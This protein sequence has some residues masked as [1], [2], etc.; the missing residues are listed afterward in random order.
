MNYRVHLQFEFSTLGY[1][2]IL[3]R[4]KDFESEEIKA[5]VQAYYDNMFDVSVLIN[6]SEARIAAEDRSQR[7]ENKL[8]DEQEQRLQQEYNSMATIVVLEKQLIMG[9]SELDKMKG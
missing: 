8:Y 3:A 7:L 9:Q 4:M 5:Q 2:Q 1:D 6:D